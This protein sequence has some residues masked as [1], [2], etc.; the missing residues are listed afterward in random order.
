MTAAE[1]LVESAARGITLRAR[2]ERNLIAVR[3][4]AWVTPELKEAIRH[5]K[6]ELL[7]LLPEADPA[8]GAA[9]I[10]P[11]VAAEIT[12]IEPEAL[13][14]GWNHGRLWNSSFW[15]HRHDEPR[16]LTSVM[17]PGDSIVEVTPDFIE[18]VKTKRS[19]VRFQRRAS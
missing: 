3:P 13:A 10:P 17:D 14:L 18:I 6:R 15:P 1:V 11:E 8:P 9:D 5:H 2:R 19:I 4:A 7:E 12:R 16:G